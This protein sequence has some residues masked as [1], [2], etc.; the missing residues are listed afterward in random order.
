VKTEGKPKCWWKTSQADAAGLID[1]MIRRKKKVCK[2]TAEKE[3][4]ELNG[5]V[6]RGDVRGRRTEEKMKQRE[7]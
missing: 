7:T 6:G 2:L 1:G 4:S 5:G 3:G